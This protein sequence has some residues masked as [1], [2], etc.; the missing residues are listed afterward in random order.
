MEN[1]RYS[2]VCGSYHDFVDIG[3]RHQRN[4]WIKSS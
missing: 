1:I 3:L 4:Y 2:R